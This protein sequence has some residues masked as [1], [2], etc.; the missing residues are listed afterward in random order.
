M[1]VSNSSLEKIYKLG[2][3]I[4]DRYQ[5]DHLIKDWTGTIPEKRFYSWLLLTKQTKKREYVWCSSIVGPL[6]ASN[7]KGWIVWP[8]HCDKVKQVNLHNVLFYYDA[9]I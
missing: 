7:Q 5:Y 3:R 6:F 8:S 4:S 2:N 9:Y 1:Q